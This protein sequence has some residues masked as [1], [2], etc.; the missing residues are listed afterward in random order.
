[1]SLKK[2]LLNGGRELVDERLLGKSVAEMALPAYMLWL[3][4]RSVC[5]AGYVFRADM[6][7]KLDMASAAPLVALHPVARQ[8]V[9]RR[10]DDAAR[11]LLYFLSPDD[12]VHGLYCCA[13]F[14]LKLVD[15]G[16][17]HDPE[18]MAVLCAMLLMDDLKLEGGVE[19]YTMKEHLL[20]TAASDL[21]A[22]A[23]KLGL[24]D[25]AVHRRSQVLHA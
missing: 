4:A 3:M 25:V 21:L 12:P 11:K 16:Y 1:M 2:Q 17:L 15:E 24:Y 6:A 19:K 18:N 23:Q 20:A 10:V 5:A 22:R 14:V 7:K 13:M 9:A 8:G